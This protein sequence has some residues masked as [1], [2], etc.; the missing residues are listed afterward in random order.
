M[1]EQLVSLIGAS[2]GAEKLYSQWVDEARAAKLRPETIQRLKR[3]GLAYTQL[4]ESG[5]VWIVRG[6]KP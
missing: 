1:E 5:N 2:D 3:K 6:A 4:D